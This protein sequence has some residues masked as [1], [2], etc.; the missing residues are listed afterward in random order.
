MVHQ[1]VA[2]SGNGPTKNARIPVMGGMEAAE[3][4]RTVCI[5][6]MPQADDGRNKEGLLPTEKLRPQ[7]SGQ[8]LVFP[9]WNPYQ[10]APVTV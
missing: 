8:I 1:E 2:S 5:L 7:H 3:H 9:W 10:V 4:W 6:A